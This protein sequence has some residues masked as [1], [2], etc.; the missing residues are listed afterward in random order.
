MVLFLH[1]SLSLLDRIIWFV[2]GVLVM[3]AHFQLC[4][5]RV[6][7]QWWCGQRSRWT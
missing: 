1:M 5:E 3:Y 6:V 2:A 7:Q 4:F